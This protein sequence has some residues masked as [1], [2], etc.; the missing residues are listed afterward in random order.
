MDYT[1]RIGMVPQCSLLR[2]YAVFH[3]LPD[4]LSPVSPVLSFFILVNRI[5]QSQA[6]TAKLPFSAEYQFRDF[7]GAFHEALP[8]FF[9][10]AVP[11]R[12]SS[13]LGAM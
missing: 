8:G 1:V 13:M 10:V 4:T 3:F 7:P 5:L 9:S 11:S 2:P 12:F 6:Q